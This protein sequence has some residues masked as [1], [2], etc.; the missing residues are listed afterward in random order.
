MKKGSDTSICDFPA[1]KTEHPNLFVIPHRAGYSPKFSNLEKEDIDLS[2]YINTKFLFTELM[3]TDNINDVAARSVY[4]RC[5]LARRVLQNRLALVRSQPDLIGQLLE[6]EGHIARQYGEAIYILK[7]KP[8]IIHRRETSSCFSELPVY[9]S[10]NE[11]KWLHP[12]TRI[13]QNHGEEIPC[14]FVTPPLYKFGNNEWFELTPL[15]RPAKP[16]TRLV[17]DQEALP[18]F[19]IIDHIGEAGL[20]R[21][22]DIRK[23][24]R[25]MVYGVEQRAISSVITRSAVGDRLASSQLDALA[26]VSPQRAESM[27]KSAINKAFGWISSF[28]TISSTL[29][30]L[31]VAFKIAKFIITTMVNAMAL[32]NLFGCSGYIL[33]A[34]FTPLVQLFITQRAPKWDVEKGD[35]PPDT[36]STGVYPSVPTPEARHTCAIIQRDV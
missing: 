7:C 28:G 21:P 19:K 25:L 30:G 36:T 24:T 1:F 8:E 29:I 32:K 34:L 33:A 13:L 18:P 27:F 6:R 10:R 4:K 17:P 35:Q 26:L 20:Y 23:L 5:L 3:H 14:S 9:N 15:P 31:V 22:D 11:T 16:P 12:V 2:T